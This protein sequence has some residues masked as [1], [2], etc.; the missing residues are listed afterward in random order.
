[1]FD[2]D[3]FTN[4]LID[5]V[6]ELGSGSCSVEIFLHSGVSFRVRRLS[7]AAPGYVLLEIFP[8]EGVTE[9][10]KDV[11][12]K[13]GGPDEVFFDRV[14]IAHNSISHVLLTVEE[15]LKKERFGFTAPTP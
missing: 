9:K 3:Y 15:P 14:A 2:A 5:Q 12:R 13:P 10:S 11:R 8:H 4:Y 7:A 1:M 6:N